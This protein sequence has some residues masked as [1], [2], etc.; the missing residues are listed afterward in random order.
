MAAPWL[1]CPCGKPH[2]KGCHGHVIKEPAD[3][4]GYRKPL[5]EPR[6]CKRPP[7][8]GTTGCQSHGGFTPSVRAAAARNYARE[9]ALAATHKGSFG[10]LRAEMREQ[11]AGLTGDQ[12]LTAMLAETG[13]W[14]LTYQVL[15]DGLDITGLLVAGQVHPYDEALR[16][17]TREH[18][19]LLKHAA[20]ISLEARRQAFREDQQ[21]RI[22]NA[23][24]GLLQGLGHDLNDPAVVPHVH[25]FVR[26]L[27]AG[28]GAEA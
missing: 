10:E 20:D 4:N 26:A 7:I 24:S 11:L 22:I 23:T 13:S 15:L 1:D 17:W 9:Q 28:D 12:Q 5:P 19:I 21:Q 18:G 16:K 14:M 25:E 8:K 2:P 6:P 3:E 27:A